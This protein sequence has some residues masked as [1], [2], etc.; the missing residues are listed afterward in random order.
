MKRTQ[1]RGLEATIRRI[2]RVLSDKERV[3]E[4][5]IPLSRQL[6]RTCAEA[7]REVRSGGPSGKLLEKARAAAL[8]MKQASG[9]YPELYHSGVVQNALQELAEAFVLAA[10]VKGQRLPAPETFGCT[11]DAYL[12]GIG[13][14]IG[15]LRR[16]AQDALRQGQYGEAED[17]LNVMEGLFSALT[18]Y[19]YPDAIAPVKHKQDIAR[20]LIEK[21]RGEVTVAARGRDLELKISALERVLAQKKAPPVSKGKA[22]SG[23]RTA[24]RR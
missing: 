16:V 15:E 7:I 9:R 14:A 24:G 10:L 12:L 8:R 3:R 1:L 5:T 21:T 22:G 19:D 23:Q 4:L 13:D 2:D 6:I 17:T 11:P 18:L 20:G